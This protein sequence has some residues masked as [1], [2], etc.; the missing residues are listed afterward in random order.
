MRVI[1]AF[2]TI[3]VTKDGRVHIYIRSP[4]DKMLE[5]LHG[6]IV[7]LDIKIPENEEERNILKQVVEKIS[8]R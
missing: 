3:Y 1:H 8:G 6:Q 4:F 7:I 2:G 5:N